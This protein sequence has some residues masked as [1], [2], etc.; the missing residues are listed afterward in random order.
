MAPSDHPSNGLTAESSMRT[1]AHLAGF[2]FGQ[3][4][5]SVVEAKPFGEFVVEISDDVLDVIADPEKGS[6][7]ALALFRSNMRLRHPT[8][9]LI[10]ASSKVIEGVSTSP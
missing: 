8:L 9:E 3:Q 1:S 7:H 5:V 2:E 4:D 10:S 6:L